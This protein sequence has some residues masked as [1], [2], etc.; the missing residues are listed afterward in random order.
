MIMR[1]SGKQSITGMA[2][3]NQM[4]LAA[5]WKVESQPVRGRWRVVGWKR[6][7]IKDRLIFLFDF[8]NIMLL[9]LFAGIHMSRPSHPAVG[10]LMAAMIT[11]LRMGA[12]VR[13]QEL[14]EIVSLT[15]AVLL[16]LALYGT[17]PN[18]KKMRN[19]HMSFRYQQ[20]F[21]RR[22]WSSTQTQ[23][24]PELLKVLIASPCRCAAGSSCLSLTFFPHSLNFQA[25]P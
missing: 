14:L 7:S 3:V 1:S 17:G 2:V 24:F 10:R 4:S 8:R 25:T 19:S 22:C 16:E 13:L 11:W 5:F 23:K 12:E 6:N 20:T 21:S 15:H 9:E 18:T